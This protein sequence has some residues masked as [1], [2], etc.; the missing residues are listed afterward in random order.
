MS[1]AASGATTGDWA[2]RDAASGR[3]AAS[4]LGLI[5]E[6]GRWDSD[7]AFVYARPSIVAHLVLSAAM[8]DHARVDMESLLA[9]LQ[10]GQ[11]VQG[12]DAAFAQPAHF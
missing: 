6:R 4:T 3:V 2:T 9:S 10:I 7:V 1:A 8:G 5:K 12:Q 11:R